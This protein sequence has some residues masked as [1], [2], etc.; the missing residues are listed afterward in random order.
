MTI[1][2]DEQVRAQAAPAATRRPRIG[3]ISWAGTENLGNDGC[4][5]SIVAFVREN[6]PGAELVSISPGPELVE[7]MFGL[8]GVPI[9]WTPRHRLMRAI[10]KLTLKLPAAIVD[11]IITERTL[12]RIDY[13]IFAGT[14]LVDD[15]RTK[16]IYKPLIFRRW[17]IGAKRRGVKLIYASVGADPVRN[18]LAQRLMQPIAGLATYRS[19]RDEGSRAYLANIGADVADAPVA[20]DL[21]WRLPTPPDPPRPAGG[22][23]TIGVGVMAYHGWRSIEAGRDVHEPYVEKI[24]QFVD[25]VADQGHR[26]H[27]LVGEKSDRR[28]VAAVSAKARCAGGPNWI[29]PKP[30]D[31]LHQLMQQMTGTDIVV[32]SRF[33]NILAALKLARPTYSLGYMS[34]CTELLDLVGTPGYAQM[35]ED[36]DLDLLKQ[37]V[38]DMIADRAALTQTIRASLININAR[39]RAQDAELRKIIV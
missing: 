8:P 38:N 9:A 11:R 21:V 35:I 33:H 17:L 23:L 29:E 10:D 26:V 14:S 20:P 7:K 12:G 13:L 36:F 37:Q 30:A 18:K 34:K 1:E 32:A 15:Y 25:W 31:T 39:M 5:E 28:V 4:L 27:L 24:T 6:F 22:P 19:Y 16:P 2:A 3:F